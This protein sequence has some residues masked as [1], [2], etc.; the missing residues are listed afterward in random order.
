MFTKNYLNNLFL[1]KSSNSYG[2]QD[3][4][5]VPPFWNPFFPKNRYISL[6][7]YP[8]VTILNSD[9]EN[10]TIKL[11]AKFH[12]DISISSIFRAITGSKILF[13]NFPRSLSKFHP[14]V[15]I[16]NS[17]QNIDPKKL[18]GQFHIMIHQSV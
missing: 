14:D 8:N 9:R 7:F 5:G 1:S 18:H 13:C 6:K 10:S 2:F 16:L 3:N 17:D 11:S 15:I 4:L 12:F